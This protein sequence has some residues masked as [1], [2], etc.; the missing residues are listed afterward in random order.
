MAW[1]RVIREFFIVGFIVCGLAYAQVEVWQELKGKHF[2]V[3]FDQP[4]EAVAKTVLRKAE[5]YYHT[6]GEQIGY[7]RYADFW[8]WEER[9]KIIIFT[10]QKSFVARTG[11]PLWSTAYADRDSY[12]FHSRTIVTYKQEN[13]FYDGILPHE[14]SH[15]ILKDFI[16]FD[17]SVPIWFEEGV[18]Q[19]QE[20][21]KSKEAGHL[22]R[23]LV[24][25]GK[26]IPIDTLMHSDIS[27][28]HDPRSVAV[29]YAQSLSIVEFLIQ[30][31]GDSAFADLCRNLKDG[32]EFSEA[33]R[34][35]YHNSM[36][37][38]SDLERKWLKFLSH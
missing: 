6:I 14:I 24:K 7:T 23:T 8:T 1:R 36:G 11:Q 2:V 5:R 30:Q 9:V 25:Q 26:Y 35:A 28:E 38:F 18:A 32:K 33:L 21:Q 12:L 27:K 10:D 13:N 16:S 29:F 34:L 4:D 15:L 37:S 19:L 17:V 31:Y 22:M 20:S 3:Y